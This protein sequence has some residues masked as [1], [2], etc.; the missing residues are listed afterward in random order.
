MNLS[1]QHLFGIKSRA[2]HK[3]H[4]APAPAV[5][6][7]PRE[8][9]ATIEDGS[10]NALRRQLI[11]V[12]LKDSMRRHGIPVHWLDC[13]MLLVSSASRGEGMYLRIIMKQW[14]LR[15]LTYALAFEKSLMVDITRF[16]PHASTW[17]YGI[18]WQ[19]EVGDSCPY[20]ELPDHKVWEN[21]PVQSGAQADL[22]QDLARMFAIRDADML[23]RGADAA[24][25]YEKTQPQ[26]LPP[27]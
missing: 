20:Q 15:M 7:P 25:N 18:S 3:S 26:I 2:K 27:R 23:V 24:G 17:L 6:E 16:E 12:L 9:P 8:G 1:L 22:K 21:R 11:Q 10:A 4:A 5:S 13:Q 14:D 19:F